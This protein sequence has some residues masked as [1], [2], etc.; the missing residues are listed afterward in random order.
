[1]E[2]P[3]P[4]MEPEHSSDNTRSLTAGLSGNSSLSFFGGRFKFLL[5]MGRKRAL[6]VRKL[7][8]LCRIRDACLEMKIILEGF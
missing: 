7:I 8:V 4:G 6:K 5:Q 3:R 1:M 2:V